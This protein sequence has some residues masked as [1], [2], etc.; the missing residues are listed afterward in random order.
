MRPA[1]PS[2]ANPQ[3]AQARPPRARPPRARSASGLGALLAVLLI[4]SGT[5][6]GAQPDEPAPPDEPAQG[7]EGAA[8]RAAQAV[9]S[10][11]VPRIVLSFSP[12]AHYVGERDLDSGSGSVE[13]FRAGA[14][15]GASIGIGQRGRLNLG[16][17]AIVT[18]LDVSI[19]PG[20]IG[21][22]NAATIADQFDEIVELGLSGIYTHTYEGGTRLFAG[23]G[24]GFAGEGDADIGDSF[25]WNA[26]GGLSVRV[27][28]NLR[29]GGGIGV[30]A[31]L[32]DGVRVVPIPVVEL[33]IDER[34]T[35]ASERAGVK[36]DY[37]TGDEVHVGLFARFEGQD[38]RIDDDNTLVPGGAVAESGFPISTY[39][40]LNK[41][42]SSGN[43]ALR[44]EVGVIVGA[45]TEIFNAAGN[46]VVVD[47]S[48]DSVFAGLRLR[49]RF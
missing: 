46:T 14:E 6:P 11:A 37:K 28:D 43:I 26:L 29:L 5:A 47:D 42:G 16:L 30:F 32:E 22:T 49:L 24:V 13:S 41:I 19:A 27:D 48:D 35:L 40:E 36:L 15:L 18:G 45:E 20:A 17:D 3:P 10:A 39:L 38:Y 21:G 33:T 31:Q 1:N 2:P 44:A 23:G 7:D 9:E 12:R 8:S 25:V 4:A 34:W